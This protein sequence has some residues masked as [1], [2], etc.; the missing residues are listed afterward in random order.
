MLSTAQI[1]KRLYDVNALRDIGVEED[2]ILSKQDILYWCLD[3]EK[4]EQDLLTKIT[5][6]EEE[7]L[8]IPDIYN[9][10]NKKRKAKIEE[11]NFV[12]KEEE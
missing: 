5:R 7:L 6:I 3:G 10:Q 1:Q 4:T 11:L 8:A 12:L 9:I 2:I